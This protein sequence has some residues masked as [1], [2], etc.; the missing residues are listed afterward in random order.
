VGTVSGEVGRRV[1][2]PCS[3]VLGDVEGRPARVAPQTEHR[4]DVEQPDEDHNAVG[5]P[6][7]DVLD[8]DESINLADSDP[9]RR[10]TLNIL[11]D[12][13]EYSKLP[14]TVGR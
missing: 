2:E 4:T 5:D 6:I 11:S 7:E 1:G 13:I 12:L 3:L 8:D 9:A 14:R 10:E